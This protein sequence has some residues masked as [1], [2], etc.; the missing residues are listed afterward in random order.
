MIVMIDRKATPLALRRELLFACHHMI[1]TPITLSVEVGEFIEF[2]R[3]VYH[4]YAVLS[5]GPNGDAMRAPVRCVVNGNK[6]WV[7]VEDNAVRYGA[8]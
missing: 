2:I 3:C 4:A 6:F 5:R 7:R 1:V 8:E